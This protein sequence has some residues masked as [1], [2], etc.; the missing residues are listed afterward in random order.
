[1]NPRLPDSVSRPD[2]YL[3][4]HFW[5]A[6]SG[7]TGSVKWAA[8]SK[9]ALL[10]SAEA[11]NSHLNVSP[12]DVWI[13]P[14]PTFHVGGLSI[15]ARAYLSGSRV[16]SMSAWDPAIFVEQCAIESASLASLVPAQLFDLVKA[17]FS[18]PPSMRAVIIGGG[19][20]QKLLFDEACALGWPVAQSFG[21]TECAS[22]IAT[23]SPGRFEMQVLPH[24]TLEGSPLKVKSEALLTGYWKDGTF[25][26]PKKDGWFQTEDLVKI[27]GSHLVWLGREKDWIKILGE[28]VNLG[29]L[30]S[31]LELLCRGVDG[32]LYPVPDERRGFL[33][34]LHVAGS[35][36]QALE[37][38]ERFN[39]TVMPYERVAEVRLVDKIERSPLGKLMNR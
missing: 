18:A 2:V 26:D 15:L 11:V 5:I 14:L 19:V 9:R 20:L 32:A 23:A 29:A 8:L 30:Q 25:W 1:M 6:T 12:G 10:L 24:V 4:G 28:N 21:M 34:S 35:M 33:L 16:V 17:K 31:K 38:K 22:Q 13:N 3:P 39:L 36:D 7:T 37:L 27:E